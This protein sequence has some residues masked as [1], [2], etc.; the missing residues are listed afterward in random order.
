M[1]SGFKKAGSLLLPLALL[2]ALVG[3]DKT[4]EKGITFAETSWDFGQIRA[5]EKLTHR[6]SF[7]NT[8]DS[9]VRIINITPSC[10]C[11]A[12]L[13]G[14]KSVLP[15]EY[16]FI[17][18]IFNPVGKKNNF[19]SFVSVETDEKKPPYLLKLEAE[20][21]SKPFAKVKFQ[22]PRPSITVEPVNINLGTVKLGDKALYKIVIGNTGEGDLFIKNIGAKNEAGV[23]LK[24]KAIKKGKR[25]ELTAFYD[26]KS[27]GEIDDYIKIFS[28]DPDRPLVKIKITGNIK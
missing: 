9:T 1:R 26:A 24:R 4:G 10:G 6:F 28:N 5:T 21:V 3:L 16:G 19:S 2:A 25:V 12:V 18:V 20:I 11:M 7:K 15:G 14:D 13:A 22:G 27:K 17:D 23:P 8:G